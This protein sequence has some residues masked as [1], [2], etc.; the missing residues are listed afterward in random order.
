[1]K[2]VGVSHEDDKEILFF[3]LM[4]TEDIMQHLLVSKYFKICMLI[5][6]SL[7]AW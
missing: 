5:S 2:Q 7:K 4:I 6:K 3:A 1:M